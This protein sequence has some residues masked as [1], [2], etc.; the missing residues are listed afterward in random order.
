MTAVILIT[1]I[2]LECSIQRQQSEGC[3]TDMVKYCL[4][5]LDLFKLLCLWHHFQ[6]FVFR[7]HWLEHVIEDLQETEVVTRLNHETDTATRK[8]LSPDFKKWNRSCHQDFTSRLEVVSRHRQQTEFI[9]RLQNETKAVPPG[10]NIEVVTRLYMEVNNDQFLNLQ[11]VFKQ[12][13]NHQWILVGF[14][15]HGRNP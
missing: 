1:T 3:S 2:N 15:W 8:K 11:W 13:T 14:L 10:D 5:Y 9:T 4:R 7:H 12:L 6:D